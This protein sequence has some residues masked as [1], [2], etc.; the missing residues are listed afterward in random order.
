MR[1][2]PIWLGLALSL[3]APEQL[4]AGPR[5]ADVAR[6][7]VTASRVAVDLVVRDKQGELLRGLTRAD[8]EVYEDG[9]RQSVDSLEFVERTPVA[10]ALA[11]SVAAAEPPA[12]LAVVLDGLGSESLRAARDALA[13]HLGAPL[14]TPSLVGIFAIERSLRQLQAFT[15]NPETLRRALDALLMRSA[16]GF[17]GLREREDVR[18]AHAGLADGSPQTSAV[19]AELAGEPECRMSG[20]DL[21]RRFK[22]LQG[23]IK[24]SFDILERDQRGSASMNGLL[25][26][27]DGLGAVPGRKAVLLFSEG[28]SLPSGVEPRFRSVVAAANRAGVSVYAADAMGLRPGNASD[29]TRRSLETL[30]TRLELVQALPPGTRGPGAAEMGD[31]GLALL[32][33]NDDLLRSAPEGGLSR[34]ADQ[35]GGFLLH[36]TNDFGAGLERIEEELG[37]YYLLSYTPRNPEYDGRF[38]TIQVKVTRPHGRVQSRQ[39]YLALRT[40]MP[41]PVL[42]DEAPALARLEA[43][44][45]P[46]LVPVR[47]RV[48]EYPEEASSF[49]VPI[50][51]EVS[52]DG[53]SVEQRSERFRR[54]FTVLAVVRDGARRVVAK[55]SERYALATPTKNAGSVLFYKEA[56]LAPGTYTVEVLAQDGRSARAGGARLTLE[57]EPPAVGHLRA[58]SLI[59]VAKAARLEP[60]AETAPEAL[61]YQ[62]VLLL[63]EISESVRAQA[64]KPIVLFVTAWP[65]AERPVVEAQLELLH[66]GRVLR[67]LSAGRH[68]AGPDGRVQIASSFPAETLPPGAYE[69]RVTLSDGQDAETRRESLRVER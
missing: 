18:H 40:P 4:D 37:A 62:G 6:F 67:V 13:S 17:S 60:R 23:R 19:P 11:A 36:G 68:L 24:E 34:L 21:V 7:G 22:V 45:L 58:S 26:L 65:N 2:L 50:V 48:L 30:R 16:T 5:E 25:S 20:D 57:L 55:M 1:R 63:P 41:S 51:V 64:G 42:E 69:L 14:R 15:D 28:L 56:R 46:T 35:T 29:E 31:S 52:A 47:V 59:R 53:F 39:G 32:E 61:R 12:V 43:G 66:A 9:V 38:R 54:D 44:E 49:L 33:R 8:V 10:G 27:V 3:Q